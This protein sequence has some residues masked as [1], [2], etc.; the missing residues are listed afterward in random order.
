ME[1]EADDGV[2]VSWSLERSAP[3]A[4]GVTVAAV[5]AILDHV[6]TDAAAQGVMVIRRGHVI[7]ERYADGFSVDSMGTS[8][9]VA[10]SIYAAAI[11]I[12]AD[13]GDLPLD[14][15]ASQWLNEW[16][17]TDRETTTVRQLLEMRGG[18]DNGSI[19][20]EADQTQFALDQVPV[21][22]AGTDFQYSNPTSQLFEPLLLRATGRNAH[23]FISERILTPI[24]IEPSAVG[25]WFD[26]TGMNP[27]TYCCLDMTIEAFARFGLLMLNNGTWNENEIVSHEFVTTSRSPQTPFYGLQWWIMNDAYF[28]AASPL[29]IS[30]AL[31]LDGQR[32][33]VW[34]EFET[35]VVVLSQYEA[36]ATTSHVVSLTN[37][38]R[39]CTARNTCEASTGD[40]VPAYGEWTFLSLLA[41]LDDE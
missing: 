14:S 4:L 41:A 3:E 1:D 30:A 26:P 31:G 10:K 15:P 2:A 11:G 29:P 36:A 5:A 21:R 37:W 23:E 27:M 22:D 40:V 28:D 34:D 39:T 16:A 35:I 38:P 17:G 13:D 6:F 33:Y 20:V 25:F 24:G 32:I 7:G 18:F 12:A 19:F 8:W 9:S